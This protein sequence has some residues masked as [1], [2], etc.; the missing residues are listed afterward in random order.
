MGKPLKETIQGIVKNHL[1]NNNG[2]A[3]GQCLTAVGWVGGTLPELYE[4]DGMIE[5]PTCDVAGGAIATGFGLAG[6]RPIYIIRYQGFQWY[7]CI[8]IINYAAKAKEMWGTPCPI[9]I[10]SIG[11]EGGIGPV[12]SNCHHGI[13]TRMPGIKVYAPMTS[14]EYKQAWK[15]F[16]NDD[17]PYYISEH[18]GSFNIDYE[19]P[20]QLTFENPDI[21]VI[22]IS[23]TRVNVREAIPKFVAKNIKVNIY[24][25]VKLKPFD[26]LDVLA[27]L[28]DKSKHGALI[29]DDDYENGTAKSLAADLMLKTSKKVHTLGLK[30]RCAGFGKTKDNLAPSAE[31]ILHKIKT[32]TDK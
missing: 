6:R 31:E 7:N 1:L 13:Y 22:P 27:K 4:E 20:R 23:I 14:K 8:T 28:I 29:I 17:E 12:A 19:M 9:F 25:L 26:D 3:L 10:R 15:E 30:E 32:I 2:V 18:R 11:M 21:V 16:Q 24:D 5:L